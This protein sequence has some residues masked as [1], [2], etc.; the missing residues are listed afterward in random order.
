MTFVCAAN[1]PFASPRSPRLLL[2]VNY[3]LMIFVMMPLG[4]GTI[5]KSQGCLC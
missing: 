1:V 3:Y 5:R 2:Q 4:F